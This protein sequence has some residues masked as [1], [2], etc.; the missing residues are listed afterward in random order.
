MKTQF[1]VLIIEDSSS[2]QAIYR[3]FLDALGYAVWV[4]ASK[5]EA[6][7][8]LEQF[9]FDALVI[10]IALN[11]QNENNKDGLDILRWLSD[12]G[13]ADRAFMNSDYLDKE[14]RQEIDQ[15]CPCAVIDKTYDDRFGQLTLC[16]ARA[17]I[18]SCTGK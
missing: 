13:L 15:L 6:L 2:W 1:R 18:G 5:T 7:L 10:D 8:K 3:D 14:V 12:R 17:A 4:A 16:L 9:T 11:K